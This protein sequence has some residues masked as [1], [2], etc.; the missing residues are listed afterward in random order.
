MVFAFRFGRGQRPEDG[1]RPSRRCFR[2]ATNSSKLTRHPTFDCSSRLSNAGGRLRP[3]HAQQIV[4]AGHK[5][6]PGLRPFASAVENGRRYYKA[7]LADRLK[8]EWIPLADTADRP[9][10]GWNNIRPAAG[11]EPRTDNISHGELVRDGWDETLT[12]DPG[13]LRFIFQGM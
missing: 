12:V 8:G 7:Y 4:G 6:N 5:V 13:N 3:R 2:Q 9:C 10:A 1:L 11:V